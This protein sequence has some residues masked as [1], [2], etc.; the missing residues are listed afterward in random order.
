[1]SNV[2]QV[3]HDKQAPARK[4]PWTSLTAQHASLRAQILETIGQILDSGMY[5]AGPH[6][7]AFEKAFAEHEGG[8]HAFAVANGT[9]ALEAALAALGV[10]PGDDV[11][12]PPNSFFATSEAILLRGAR[13]VYVD[14]D[15]RTFTIDVTK[16]TKA[17]T[18]KTKAVLPVHLYGLPADMPAIRAFAD[19]HGLVVL[20]DSCQAHGGKIHGRAH[21]EWADATAYSFYPTKNLGTVGEGGGIVTSREDVAEK[22][23]NL[24][25]HGQKV[26]NQ[27]DTLGANLRMSE[28]QGAILE[29][30]LP[31]LD[32]WIAAR[33]ERAA[34]YDALLTDAKNVTTPAVPDG[35]THVYHLYVI[36]HPK[37]DA[38][39][40]AL[41]ARGVSTSIHYPGANHLQAAVASLGHAAGSFPEAERAVAEILTIPLFPELPME[42]VEYVANAIREEAAKL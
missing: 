6:L 9:V 13:P 33:R 4:I 29:I 21:A 42:D 37:R 20:A 2:T 39:A 5:V 34:R 18:P 32:E 27:H 15:S 11:L 26:K 12:T 24:R 8:K 31:H 7:A 40:A 1:M 22:I 28:I 19:T 38:L 14:I 41:A 30:K 35:F 17:L 25:D 36:R 16:L 10:G 3:A 23:R